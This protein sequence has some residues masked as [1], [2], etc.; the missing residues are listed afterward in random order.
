MVRTLSLGWLPHSKVEKLLVLVKPRPR[1]RGT[2]SQSYTLRPRSF[3][4]V[5]GHLDQAQQAFCNSLECVHE[6]I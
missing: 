3:P 2:C 4:E 5:V 1:A 6:H